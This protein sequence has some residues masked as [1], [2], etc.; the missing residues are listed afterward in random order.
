MKKTMCQF[1]KDES[2]KISLLAS[3]MMLVLVAL[4]GLIGN[5]GH[6]TQ[7]KLETQNAADSIAYSSAL[8]MARGMNAVTASNHMIGEATA[9]SVVHEAIG[10]P[11]LDLAVKKN[12]PENQTLDRL[13][14]A[15]SKTAPVFPSIYSP[16]P[17]PNIDRRIVEFVTKR[18]SPTN[19]R[20]SAFAT[21]YD[22][23]MTLKRE[24]ALL[25]P[26]KSLAN[27]GFLVPPPWGFATAA[28]SYVVHIAGTV[29]VVLIGKEWFVL[30]ALE[31]IAKSFKPMKSVVEKQLVP[32]LVEHAN[33]VAGIDSDSGQ[34]KPGIL[35]KAAERLV[36]DLEKRLNVEAA[37]FPKFEKLK[38]PVVPEPKPNM[39]GTSQRASEWGED[40]PPVLPMPDLKTG[41]MKR[42]LDRALS[43]MQKRLDKLDRDLEDLDDFESDIEERLEEDDVDASEKAELEREQKEIQESR[44]EK[45]N[46][47][48]EIDEKLDEIR[49]KQAE[50]NQST[51]QLPTQSDNPSIKSIPRQMDQSQ[52][53]YTQWVRATYPQADALRAP[54]RAWLK[55]WARKSNAAEHFDKWTN[56]YTLVKAWQFRSGY[57]T[58]KNGN[59]VTWS[60]NQPSLKML[61]M[62]DT[63]RGGSRERKG[64]ERWTGKN[65]S[66]KI[67]AEK[68]FTLMGVA[69]RD[70]EPL[71][72]ALLY[73]SPSD[74]GITTYAQSIFYNANQQQPG[75]GRG[76]VQEKVGW[77]TLNW[78]PGIDAPEW[79]APAHQSSP[80][81]PWEAFDGSTQR[82]VAKVKLNWQAKLMPVRNSRLKETVVT[83]DG[84]ARKN[85]EHATKYFEKLGHH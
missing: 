68:L 42:K 44:D 81:W 56:R 53:R 67:E 12:T 30:R 51:G 60:K 7:E 76:R 17:I 8:W 39:R 15:L 47:I 36:L 16:A 84:L 50:L 41:S 58:R 64:Y 31:E 34:P 74:S 78:D 33:F 75:S 26:A 66:A 72:S 69:H 83:V 82:D 80:K 21:I 59:A 48:D 28:A 40:K 73:P 52:E 63:F 62:K 29:N 27:L 11:E 20:M 19:G 9:M 24:L 61:V 71:F 13:I 22:S 14:Q 35:N 49:T 55:K 70:Y 4:A 54:I 6:V 23:R 2:G 25:L 38:L 79:G 46:R 1:H 77:D 85:L 3:M 45:Q 65:S 10:G 37:L 57:R 18:T 32:T 5:T 43:R